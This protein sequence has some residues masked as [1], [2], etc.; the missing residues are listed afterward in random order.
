MNSKLLRYTILGLFIIALAYFFIANQDFLLSLGDKSDGNNDTAE[1]AEQTFSK[2]TSEVTPTKKKPKK[3]KKST[4]AAA[5]GLSRFYA[6]INADMGNKGP[7]IKNNVVFL[8]D[9]TSDIVEILEARRMVVRPLRKNWKST[10]QSRPFRLGETLFQKLSEY[11]NE[12]G[13]EVMW[14]LNRDF[15]VKDAFRIDKDILK[16]AY[17]VGN[18]VQGHFINGISTYFCYQHRA[19]VLIDQEVQYLDDECSLLQTSLTK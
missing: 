16:V 3:E 4:N 17:Q 13:L 15:I 18:A 8:P 19:I 10:K 11:A 12:E 9:V 6:S 5:D 7:K 2:E 14:W 1:V